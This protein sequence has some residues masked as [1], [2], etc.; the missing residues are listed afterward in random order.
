MVANLT[1]AIE[2]RSAKREHRF[3]LL[4]KLKHTHTLLLQQTSKS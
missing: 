4:A 2:T 3:K 1:D